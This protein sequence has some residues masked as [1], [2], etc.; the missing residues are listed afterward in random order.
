MYAQLI[1]KEGKSESTFELSAVDEIALLYSAAR[2]ISIHN[3][4]K[5]LPQVTVKQ[6]KGIYRD[7]RFSIEFEGL[8]WT[9]EKLTSKF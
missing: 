3:K 5:K 4:K 6:L 7:N 8:K 2:I 9:F 1:R